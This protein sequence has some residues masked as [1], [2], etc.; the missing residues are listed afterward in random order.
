MKKLT[1]LIVVIAVVLAVP[2]AQAQ[3]KVALKGSL[4]YYVPSDDDVWDNGYGVDGQLQ[5]WPSDL[6]GFALSIGGAKWDLNGESVAYAANG[7]FVSGKGGGDATLIPVG[8]SILV[9]PV[10]SKRLALTLEGGVRYVVVD[11]NADYKITVS[12][13]DRVAV[14]S[15]SGANGT[16]L[17]PYRVPGETIEETAEYKADDA[18]IG[19]VQADLEFRASDSFS[20]FAGCGWQFDITKS[21]ASIT[22][23]GEKL[24]KDVSMQAFFAKAGIGIRF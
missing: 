12:T 15:V 11:P 4:L 5:Y 23:L 2:F 20:L 14:G 8:A 21:E 9:C 19:L 10:S 18:V 1:G 16:R 6:L 7:Y 17:F 24:K 3:R 22:M 13:P